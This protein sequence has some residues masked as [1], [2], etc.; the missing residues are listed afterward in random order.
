MPAVLMNGTAVAERLY[1]ETETR[2]AAVAIQFGRKP[3]L[4][5]VLVGDDP[6]S[7]TYVRMK[8]R[9]CA[10]HGLES[11]S[12]RLG[13]TS[14]TEEVVAAVKAL[15]LDLSVDGILVQHPA[16]AQ[17]DER[18]VFEAIRPRKD[19][20]GVTA[21]SFSAMALGLPGHESCTP[22]GSCGSWMRTTLTSLASML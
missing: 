4:A 7:A 21:A 16:P 1:A 14:S 13:G 15:D 20:D 12:V 22:G 8:Q 2:A 18:A 5:T 19:V 11:R 9:R 10:R 17:V 3:C 6:A